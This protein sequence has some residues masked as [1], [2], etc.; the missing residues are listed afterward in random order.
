M[1][2][3]STLRGRSPSSK[4]RRSVGAATVIAQYPDIVIPPKDR[5]NEWDLALTIRGIPVDLREL[6]LDAYIFDDGKKS[7]GCESSNATSGRGRS[8][9]VFRPLCSGRLGVTARGGCTS[10]TSLPARLCAPDR[11]AVSSRRSQPAFCPGL[12][13]C[14]VH[15]VVLLRER[16][17]LGTELRC[18]LRRSNWISGRVRLS[19][20]LR[21]SALAF[22]RQRSLGASWKAALPGAA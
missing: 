9:F 20:M 8:R 19:S 7:P 18:R 13:W 2:P 15:V 21:C 12:G 10:G 17:Y 6:S 14:P 16:I 3:R 11:C 1:V 4:A 22:R 5:M